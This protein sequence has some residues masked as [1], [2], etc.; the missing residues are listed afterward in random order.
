MCCFVLAEFA[1]SLL[2]AVNSKY[3]SFAHQNDVGRANVKGRTVRRRCRELE[4]LILSY[5]AE[6]SIPT[7]TYIDTVV[8]HSISP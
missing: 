7:R 3:S 2:Q 6:I 1:E 4:C 5:S 8:K